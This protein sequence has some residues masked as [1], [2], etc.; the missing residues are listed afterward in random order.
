[1]G[2]TSSPNVLFTSIPFPSANKINDLSF[3]KKEGN[4]LL[5]SSALETIK[6]QV[7]RF[8]SS[9]GYNFEINNPGSADLNLLESK[10]KTK[11]NISNWNKVV[12]LPQEI[13]NTNELTE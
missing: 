9:L 7:S 10:S 2:L 3:A 11:K 13:N 4:K 8:A 12:N 6:S 5:K 1:M